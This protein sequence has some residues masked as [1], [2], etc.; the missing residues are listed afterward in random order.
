[1][2]IELLREMISNT[3][4]VAWVKYEISVHGSNVMIRCASSCQG[5]GGREAK[6]AHSELLC[7][8]HLDDGPDHD[9][10]RERHVRGKVNF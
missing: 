1:M 7:A 5:D 8:E 9:V 6:R 3:S 4:I 10:H 2:G